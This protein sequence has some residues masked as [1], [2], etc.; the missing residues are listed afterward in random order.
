[1]SR[2]TFV[3]GYHLFVQA[4]IR[5]KHKHLN[6]SS[7]EYTIHTVRRELIGPYLTV[8]VNK[9]VR[10]C[11]ACRVLRARPYRYPKRPDL[12]PERIAAQNPFAV[13]GID[14]AGPF[15][16]KHGRGHAKVWLAVFTCMVARAIHIEIVPDLTAVSF[17]TALRSI[18]WI[19]GTPKKILTDNATNF[20]KS[21]KVLLEIS[22]NNE[23]IKEFHVNKDK[24]SAF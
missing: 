9:V 4:Y 6:C 8:N 10:E 21:A 17:L 12:P 13:S 16:V 20:T 11:L 19:K 22:K 5:F 15:L 2:I 18:A 24:K 23:V 3:N 7:K 1:M 14:Y